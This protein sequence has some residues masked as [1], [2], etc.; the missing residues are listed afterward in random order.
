ML[1]LILVLC[2]LATVG[3]LIG[4]HLNLHPL[5]SNITANHV[6]VEKAAR[7]LTL[8]RGDTPLKVYRVAL[9][10]APVGPKKEEG[11]NGRQKEFI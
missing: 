5:P 8:L 2:C 3:I 6:L 11:I 7:R 9:G 1:L 10:R 4:A